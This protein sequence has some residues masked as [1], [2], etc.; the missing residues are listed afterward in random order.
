MHL[1]INMSLLR[2]CH[3][4]ITFVT[5][6]VLF[7]TILNHTLTKKSHIAPPIPIKVK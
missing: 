7:S 3:H 2:K 4:D 6:T 5:L 1:S